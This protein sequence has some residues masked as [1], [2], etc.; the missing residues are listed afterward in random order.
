[1]IPRTPMLVKGV[2]ECDCHVE[3]RDQAGDDAKAP[4][5]FAGP[6]LGNAAVRVIRTPVFGYE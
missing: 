6:S 5:F 4:D 3:Q 1:M 2:P